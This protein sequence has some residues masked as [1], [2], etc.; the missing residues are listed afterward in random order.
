MDDVL[1]QIR[2]KITELEAKLSDLHTTER[3]LS[4]L[5]RRELQRPKAAPKWPAKPGRK[6]NQQP[7]M[8]EPQEKRQTVGAAVTEALAGHD[9]LTVGEIAEAVTT[10]GR[11]IDNRA[12]SFALQALKKRGLVKGVDGKWT[13]PKARSRKKAEAVAVGA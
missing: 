4:A 10:S 12:I 2:F 7:V 8:E 9:P 13:V 11:P 1:E 6:A 5:E 3:E